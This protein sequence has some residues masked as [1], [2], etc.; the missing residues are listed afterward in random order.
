MTSVGFA[1]ESGTDGGSPCYAIGVVSV[2]R[3]CLAPFVERL[4]QLKAVHGVEGE[5]KW[6]R[7]R[8][9]HGLIN[10]LL[11]CLNLV[12]AEP[13]AAFD[14]IVV[15][16]DLYRNWQGGSA[17]H[18][19]AFY[20]TYT[21]LLRHIV[22]RA[23]DMTVFIDD[24][25]DSYPQRD[26]VVQTIGN[27]M[28]AKLAASGR[29]ESITK[30]RSSTAVG[31]QAADLLTGVINA[32]HVCAIRPDVAI[33][34]GKRLAI[35]RV[36]SMLGWQRLAHDTYPHPKFNIWHFPTEFRGPS[37]DPV[38][39]TAVPYVAADDISRA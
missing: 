14:V 26:E 31:I 16:K 24:R 37:R 13:S 25:S 15:R 8:T 6:T 1:D 3:D 29:L 32:A 2:A 4:M 35:E 33:H 22:R 9:S 18:E 36:A 28:L 20:K 17:E 5:A 27:R 12:V 7:V 30:T 21:Y 38:F 39:S 10:F 11:D 23:E 34:G 19:V